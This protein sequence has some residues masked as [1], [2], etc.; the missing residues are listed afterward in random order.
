MNV[1]VFTIDYQLLLIEH[2]IQFG[3]KCFITFENISA[4]MLQ[5]P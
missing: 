2:L 5:M 3:K 1:T 4:E